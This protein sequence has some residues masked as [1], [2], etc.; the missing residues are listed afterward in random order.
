MS[1]LQRRPLLVG[2]A[3]LFAALACSPSQPSATDTGSPIQRDASQLDSGTELDVGL[4]P[5]QDSGTPPATDSG[6]SPADVGTPPPE[7]AGAPPPE[8]AGAP[9]PEDA[10][11]PPP[12]D[13][14]V[15]PVQAGDPCDYPNEAVCDEN[16]RPLLI[17][18][19]DSFQP[20]WDPLACSDC[21]ADE[22]GKLVSFCAVPGF[23]GIDRAGRNRGPAPSLRH[24]S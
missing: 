14:G 20:P 12:E 4:P 7:D 10:G 15:R 16:N 17:C 13:A 8:D 5:G 18:Q 3:V 23:I 24:L 11:A 21:E 22:Q 6:V 9:P 1:R 2:S 19:G